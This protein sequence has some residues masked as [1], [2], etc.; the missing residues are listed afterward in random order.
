MRIQNLELLDKFT[1]FL[2]GKSVDEF[3]DVFD[4]KFG[5][6]TWAA[7]GFSDRFMAQG[8]FPNLPSDVKSKIERI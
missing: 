8:Y 6:G 7:G 2:E 5:S 3:L 4:I 1:R